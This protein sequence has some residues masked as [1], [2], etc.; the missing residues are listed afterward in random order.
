MQV[1]GHRIH[2]IDE[3]TGTTLLFVHGNPTW[4]FVYRE[5]IALLK[6]SFRCVA[7]DLAGFGLSEAAPG[8]S[9]LPDAQSALL[10]QLIENLDLRDY[11]VVVHDW[12]GPIGLSAGLAVPGRL[13]GAIISN[14]WGW[15]VNGDPG[16]PQVAQ[17]EPPRNEPLP[18]A[19]PPRSPHT[20]MG[21][22]SADH[23]IPGLACSPR[24]PPH[25]EPG[26][27]RASDLG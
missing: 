20:H 18:N 3:G 13:G 26:T 24:N 6:Q 17:T 15:P 4:S 9:Y 21:T 23:R 22:S 27:A 10:A 19:A 7:V 5:A 12:G 8:F 1:D 11:T 16:Q 25:R 2:D 14:T